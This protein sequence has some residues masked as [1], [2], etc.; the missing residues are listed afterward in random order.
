MTHKK[1]RVNPNSK[2]NN[3][4][5]KNS[6]TNNIHRSFSI[7]TAQIGDAAGIYVADAC[8]GAL[9]FGHLTYLLAGVG[10]SS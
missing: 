3:A 7:T 10:C 8:V 9:L 6:A 4:S 2:N 1:W 5:A